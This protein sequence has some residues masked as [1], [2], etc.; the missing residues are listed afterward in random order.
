MKALGIILAGGQSERLKSLTEIR[1]SSALPIGSC[2]RA[3]DFPISNMS[4]SGISK[5]AVITQYN[6]RSLHDH[7][8]SA[9][10]W[11]L[12]RKH[13]GLFIFNPFSSN[14]N[15]NWFKGTADAIYQNM[16]YLNRSNEEYVIITSGESVYKIDFNN[17]I[18][19][20]EKKGADITIVYQ[21][22]ANGRLNPHEFGIMEIDSEGRMLNFEEK[23][24]D[25]QTSLASLGI[26]VISRKMLMGLLKQSVADSRYDLVKDIIITYRKSLKIYGCPFEGY[27]API[28]S[29]QNYFSANMDFLRREIH[30]E[31]LR[32]APYI[33]TKPKD[34]PPAKY[35][36]SAEVKD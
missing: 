2:Y 36:H 25:P 15:Q 16:T 8:S 14:G 18:D 24:V 4:N 21:D 22:I 12:G 11:D 3:I 27:W 1:A 10:W 26:Y 33:E 6:S 34:E 5:V 29:V 23:P 19:Y 32:Q 20:H 30:E 13:G 7:L 28:N 9:K 17:V 31:F 35:N